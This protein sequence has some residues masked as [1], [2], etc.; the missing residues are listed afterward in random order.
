[1]NSICQC[2]VFFQIR[3]SLSRTINN[4][5]HVALSK[6]DNNGF[7]QD[8]VGKDL[9]KTERSGSS[10]SGV[11]SSAG[12]IGSYS[13]DSNS[14]RKRESALTVIAQEKTIQAKENSIHFSTIIGGNE[15]K[16]DAD[17]LSM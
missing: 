17:V 3:D 6:L 5:I 9:L 10:T 7:Q 14:L 11:Y 2:F 16:K 8:E 13:P 1:M 4:D 12:S 15:T